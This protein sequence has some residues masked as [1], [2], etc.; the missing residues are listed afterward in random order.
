MFKSKLS[1][2]YP[3]QYS[4]SFLNNFI[5]HP[6]HV[7]LNTDLKQLGPHFSTCSPENSCLG[8]VKHDKTHKRKKGGSY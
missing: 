3:L 8:E 5:Q 4:I 6:S 7:F 1:C 2:L